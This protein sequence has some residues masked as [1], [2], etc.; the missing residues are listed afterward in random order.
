MQ[1]YSGQF[2]ILFL[3]HIDLYR[4]IYLYSGMRLDKIVH[5]MPPFA[6]HPTGTSGISYCFE[7]SGNSD[8]IMGSVSK[9]P[10]IYDF[11]LRIHKYQIYLKTKSKNLCRV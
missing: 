4:S 6:A 5:V 10:I 2:N 1:R 8:P 11:C 3:F 9:P 7:I